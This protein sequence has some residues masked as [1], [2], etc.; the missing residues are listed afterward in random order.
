M[1]RNFLTHVLAQPAY[2]NMQEWQSG[3]VEDQINKP[4]QTLDAV[5]HALLDRQGMMPGPDHWCWH[6]AMLCRHNQKTTR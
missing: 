6:P 5:S 3:P 1:H 4:G 2:C